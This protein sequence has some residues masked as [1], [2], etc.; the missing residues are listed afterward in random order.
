MLN[1]IKNHLPKEINEKVIVKGETVF[2]N[3]ALRVRNTGYAEVH[4]NQS[5]KPVYV[6]TRIPN[7]A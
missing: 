1:Y 6:K 7:W 4:M 2:T 3:K 5:E